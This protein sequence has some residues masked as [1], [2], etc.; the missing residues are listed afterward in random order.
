MP[1]VVRGG[2]DEAGVLVT[3]TG[4]LVTTDAGRS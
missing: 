2:T 3:V 1:A 4:F